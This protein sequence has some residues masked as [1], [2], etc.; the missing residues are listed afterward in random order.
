MSSDECPVLPGSWLCCEVLVER[1]SRWA[2][3]TQGPAVRRSGL[4]VLF[5][6]WLLHLRRQSAQDLVSRICVTLLRF[7]LLVSLNEEMN[8][9]LDFTTP[10]YL[11]QNPCHSMGVGARYSLIDG[12]FGGV[13]MFD[14]VCRLALPET[15]LVWISEGRLVVK[16]AQFGED[17]SRHWIIT[18]IA[19]ICTTTRGLISAAFVKADG[20]LVFADKLP[21]SFYL[22]NLMKK[23]RQAIMDDGMPE[24]REDFMERYGYNRSN[25]NF[26]TPFER[27]GH[28][29]WRKIAESLTA[30]SLADQKHTIRIWSWCLQ[31]KSNVN[32]CSKTQLLALVRNANLLKQILRNYW[33]YRDLPAPKIFLIKK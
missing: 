11:K 20:D 8:A 32:F 7:G 23:V 6:S 26:C 22:V 29:R 25:R 5:K 30:Y 4:L 19:T 21:Q 33:D 1:T 13:D 28:V 14:C 24:F 15:A 3:W 18:V 9:V 2:E 31:V 17:F 27:R 16:N 10:Y 12:K